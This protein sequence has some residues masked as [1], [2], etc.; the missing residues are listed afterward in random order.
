MKSMLEHH[1]PYAYG[2]ELA[3][4]VLTR[5]PDEVVAKIQGYQ[6]VEQYLAQRKK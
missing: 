1:L 6:A 2:H 4:K 5:P 3:A